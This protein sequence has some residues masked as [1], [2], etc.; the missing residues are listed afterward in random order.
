MKIMLLKITE[1]PIYN[2]FKILHNTHYMS[3]NPR[4]DTEGPSLIFI[5]LYHLLYIKRSNTEIVY[6]LEYVYYS[7]S[8][9]DS[10]QIVV[11]TLVFT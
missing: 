2:T 8:T 4:K 1:H 9:F 7:Y 3:N 11:F 5:D 10:F 6:I